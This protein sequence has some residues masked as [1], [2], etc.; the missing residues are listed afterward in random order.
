MNYCVM[1]KHFNILFL[2][3]KKLDAIDACPDDGWI[4]A[5]LWNKKETQL[6]ISRR[7]SIGQKPLNWMKT[8]EEIMS[9]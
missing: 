6:R 8:K 4:G 5:T 3:N 2:F 7:L 9:S 1:D